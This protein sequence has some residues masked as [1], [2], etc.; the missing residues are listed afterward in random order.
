MNEHYLLHFET[1]AF[2]CQGSAQEN[3]LSMWFPGRF[4]VCVGELTSRCLCELKKSRFFCFYLIKIK[5]DADLVSAF[6]FWRRYFAVTNQ[7]PILILLE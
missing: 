3:A 5:I 7:G 6:E 1:I 4:G 2:E